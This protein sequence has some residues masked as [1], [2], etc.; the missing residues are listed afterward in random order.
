M[1]K[2]AKNRRFSGQLYDFHFWGQASKWIYTWVDNWRLAIPHSKNCPTLVHTSLASAKSSASWLYSTHSSASYGLDM[3]LFCMNGIRNL[4]DSLLWLA[5][6]I[7]NKTI[8]SLMNF[9]SSCEMGILIR[10]DFWAL[11]LLSISQF[12]TAILLSAILE[13]SSH[14]D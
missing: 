12:A 4:W 2:S 10:K 1:K 6:S 9:T 5:I 7:D 8:K 13:M 14:T 11:V 3:S